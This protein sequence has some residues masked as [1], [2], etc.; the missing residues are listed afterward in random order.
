M[1]LSVVPKL[2]AELPVLPA[3]VIGFTTSLFRLV[4]APDTVLTGV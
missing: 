3:K 4:K 2:F 1:I